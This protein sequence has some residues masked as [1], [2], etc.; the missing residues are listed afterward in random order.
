MAVE[1]R[2]SF[3]SYLGSVQQRKSILRELITAERAELGLPPLH[4]G[5]S[6]KR[7]EHQAVHAAAIAR[8]LS[9]PPTVHKDF[10]R[11][12]RSRRGRNMRSPD[13]LFTGDDDDGKGGGGFWIYESQAVTQRTLGG[14][15]A[16]TAT[17][18]AGEL[19]GG[20][21]HSPG[22]EPSPSGKDVTTPSGGSALRAIR[23]SRAATPSA[24]AHQT[25]T[26]ASRSRPE[27]RAGGG[28]AT[29]P[30]TRPGTSTSSFGALP[31]RDRAT[32]ASS[33]LLI[34]ASPVPTTT[35]DTRMA[36][37]RKSQL[38]NVMRKKLDHVMSAAAARTRCGL[39]FD[40][41]STS[42]II[43]RGLAHLAGQFI[44]DY[45]EQQGGSG[46][47]SSLKF[48][49]VGVTD[50]ANC[51][52]ARDVFCRDDVIAGKYVGDTKRTFDALDNTHMFAVFPTNSNFWDHRTTDAEMGDISR[53]PAALLPASP[54][55][56]ISE[57]TVF[58]SPTGSAAN[59]P[60]GGGSPTS[61]TP[62]PSK[63]RQHDSSRGG[64]PHGALTFL[65]EGTGS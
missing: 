61:A 34:E 57:M 54:G 18:V 55:G 62:S 12:P 27:S 35:T 13:I 42:G 29:A 14:D 16:E 6:R 33:S 30:V 11:G 7:A 59:L 47:T 5:N 43:K 65:T 52:A 49:F 23:S 21:G 58:A 9:T 45:L 50:N 64:A 3:R 32:A 41:I 1:F 48:I 17:T 46:R 4:P 39:L 10:L 26:G 28:A 20:R 2:D 53:R 25:V 24:A 63:S 22:E 51:C 56:L 19:H 44:Y 36:E 60:I 38:A 37:F 40:L 8:P 15:F 31:L